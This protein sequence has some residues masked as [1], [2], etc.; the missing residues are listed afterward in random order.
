MITD[1]DREVLRN[2][3]QVS[4][5]ARL[6]IMALGERDKTQ[7]ISMFGQAAVRL[8]DE[9]KTSKLTPTGRRSLL[10][11]LHNCYDSLCAETLLPQGLQTD[12]PYDWSWYIRRKAEIARELERVVE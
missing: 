3:S 4:E 1:K 7:E 12:L 10:N 5:G 2:L 9:L 11:V 8:E 6:Y